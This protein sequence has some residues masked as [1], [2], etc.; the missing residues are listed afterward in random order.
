M[1]E[2]V[3]LSID[4]GT[5]STRALLINNYGDVLA[6]AKSNH[7]PAYF[8]LQADWAEQDADFYWEHISKACL[9]LKKEKL[10]IWERME[11]VGITTIRA[12]YVCLDKDKKPLRPAFLWLD[13]RKASGKPKLSLSMDLAVKA[14]GMEKTANSQWRISV[15]NWLRENEPQTWRDT[16]HFVFVSGYLVYRLT[17]QLVDSISALVGHVPFNHKKREWMNRF[18]FKRFVFDIEPDKL[19]AFKEAGEVLGY[20]SQEAEEKTG[21]PAGMPLYAAGSD[22][23]CETI[24]MGCVTPEK[25]AVSFGTTCTVSITC[26][27]YIEPERFMP[28]Y[29]SMIPDKYNP[30]IQIYRGYWLISW[31]KKEFAGKEVEQAKSLGIAPEDLLNRRLKEIPAGCQGLVFQPYFTPNLTMPVARGAVI[32]F[33]D[34]HTRVHIYRAI[35]EGINFALMRGLKQL[36][37]KSG[38][39]IKEIYL[40]GGGSKSDEICQIT[41]DMFGITAIRTQ[42]NEVSG[43]GCAMA[44]FIGMGVFPSFE[45]ATEY[46]VRAK[47]VFVPDMKQHK[48]YCQIYRE[49]FMEIYDRLV[50]LYY[51][52]NEIQKGMKDL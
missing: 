11:G 5:Q 34:V 43:I 40:G 42:T 13:K 29:V 26:S 28:A 37:K 14:V 25:A 3:V 16:K 48:I 39:K 30:E 45:K 32:G 52:Q 51:K 4:V 46:M 23:G 31:F 49:I 50:P 24:G 22:K 33:S 12:T 38:T 47:D 19:C 41:A 6:S 20:I 36:E 15:C 35:I 1:R 9:E 2:R 10:E 27:D 18:S 7:N 44:C 21:I 17:G 8:S